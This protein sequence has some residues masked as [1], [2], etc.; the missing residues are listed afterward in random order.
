MISQ[1]IRF[2][3]GYVIFTLK[4]KF[5]ERFVNLSMRRGNPF[6]YINPSEGGFEGAMLLSDYRHV[7]PLA[8]KCS[9][10]LKIKK[11]VG[12][13]FFLFRYRFRKGLLWGL[14]LFLILSILMRNFLWSVE[15]NGIETLSES[16]ISS[17][18]R[19]YSVFVGSPLMMLDEGFAERKLT[20]DNPDIGW[21]SVNVLG[22]SAQVEIKEKV[23]KPEI[24][25]YRTPCN[26]VAS[27]DGLILEMNTKEG[28]AVMHKGSAVV[29][30]QLLVSGAMANALDEIDYVHSA[31]KVMAQTS[32]SKTFSVSSQTKLVS[33]VKEIVRH[34]GLFLFFDFPLTFSSADSENTLR[35]QTEKLS[36]NGIVLPMGIRREFM[37]QYEE[38]IVDIDKERAEAILSTEDYLYRF[39][40]LSHC[41][42]IKGER[43]FSVKE[44]GFELS[45][46][47]TCVE[48]IAKEQNIIVN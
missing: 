2:L 26:I 36:L 44:E 5:P 41:E 8:K 23:R 35:T 4:G 47:Y 43:M 32:E 30:G 11:R 46:D 31:A 20:E 39:F 24:V 45:V 19:K 14:L 16:E 33:P 10:I 25:D 13:P 7:R 37:T 27:H 18:L 22:T 12:L 28:T 1:I 48:D 38:R 21:V 17:D 29:K 3:R 9:V 34:R 42:E 15:I 6:I 40:T